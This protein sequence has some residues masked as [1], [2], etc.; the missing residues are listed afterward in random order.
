[1]TTAQITLAVQ[2]VEQ[3]HILDEAGLDSGPTH[4]HAY[5][6]LARRTP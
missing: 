6:L 5:A 4:D 2:L 3:A 1:M